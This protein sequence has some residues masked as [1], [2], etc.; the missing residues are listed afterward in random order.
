MRLVTTLATATRGRPSSTFQ[1]SLAQIVV[2]AQT[3]P[4]SARGHRIAEARRKRAAS[5]DA[6]EASRRYEALALERKAQEREHCQRLHDKVLLARYAE[7]VVR[8]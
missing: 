3:S 8:V 5:A 6:R 2:H 7:G 4:R 1:P